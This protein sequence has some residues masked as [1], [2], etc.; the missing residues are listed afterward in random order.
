MDTKSREPRPL[1]KLHKRLLACPKVQEDF[2]RRVEKTEGCWIWKGTV[3]RH[4][5]GRF[6]MKHK[7]FFAHRIALYLCGILLFPK[8][9]T[10]HLC[11][12]TLCVNPAHIELVT[13]AENTLRGFSLPALNARKTHCKR[14]HIFNT[15]NTI[16]ASD[17]HRKCRPCGLLTD[18]LQ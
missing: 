12:N 15:R 6:H 13:S 17:G 7:A 5:Y 1:S 18:S 3:T 11:R 16:L 2:W 14:G 4:G 10:D 8:K 9:V